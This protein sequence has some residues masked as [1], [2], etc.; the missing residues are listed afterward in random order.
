[1]FNWKSIANDLRLAFRMSTRHPSLKL[2]AVAT[3][4]LGI[5]AN[6]AIFTVVDA[7]IFRQLPY[8]HSEQLVFFQTHMKNG[9]TVDATTYPNFLEWRKQSHSFEEVAAVSPQNLIISGDGEAEPISA[10]LVSADYFGMLRLTPVLGRL[11]TE[12]ETSHAGSAS[13]VIISNGLWKRRFGGDHSV[14]GKTLHLNDESFT[15]VGVLSAGEKGTSQKADVWLPIT[16][17]GVSAT[18]HLL[19]NRVAIWVNVIGRLD[20]GRPVSE[21]QREVEVMAP[22]VAAQYP[23]TRDAGT[24]VHLV[25][26]RYRTV[27]HYREG[28]LI[29]FGA[30]IFVL[31]IACVNVANLLLSYF[32]DRKSEL[33]VR[34]ALGA[35]RFRLV[36]QLLLESI[37][38]ASYGGIV[39]LLLAYLSVQWLGRS[40]VAVFPG[41]H[42]VAINGFVLLFTF[43]ISVVTGMLVGLLPLWQVVR[44]QLIEGLKNTTRSGSG[45]GRATLRAGLIVCQ[46]GLAI[47][48]LVGA[49]LMLR[50]MLNLQKVDVGFK[51]D[52]LLVAR[53]SSLP[54]SRY[55][56]RE[57]M[58]AFY[59][60]I[61][62]QLSRS[63]QVRSVGAVTSFP[64]VTTSP[65]MPFE[66]GG[67]PN[68]GQPPTARYLAVSAGYF[69]TMGIPLLR[70][71]GFD[72]T[73]SFN[74][75]PVIV[76]NQAMANQYWPGSDP[77]GKAITIFD[78][79]T[80]RQVIGVV[81]DIRD[82]SV[83]TVGTAEFYIPYQQ[84]P[85]G[86]VSILRSFPP[87]LAIRTNAP[88]ESL[89]NTLRAIVAGADQNEAVLNLTRVQDLMA[90]SVAQP[91]LY[92]NLLMVFAG[93]A[94]LLAAIGIYGVISYSVMQRSREIGVRLAL[95]AT[96]H[97]ILALVF[98]QGM[99]SILL[100]I[101]G[102]IA[103]AWALS[104]VLHNFLYE[105][106][107]A[108]PVSFALAVGV[109]TAAAGLACYIPAKR[110]TRVDPIA[111]LR[112]D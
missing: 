112:H 92:T 40:L 37:L 64:L 25:P 82:S 19:E 95:G 34:S 77:L 54:A 33:A 66:I 49:G 53:L 68:Q 58:I 44:D 20:S 101:V 36:Q 99:T 17:I 83:N 6:T 28:L 47:I 109:I 102:G 59:D 110:A 98:R 10:E 108:D 104:R 12:E 81:G 42:H 11:F 71:R 96:R 69:S 85:P 89:S 94:L 79:S 105:I 100:G 65:S 22:S 57:K 31:L 84:I 76:L 38:L 27:E 2:I 67:R 5:G 9:Q 15:I 21:A 7:A 103:G 46:M 63:P 91:K 106:K 75:V 56:M 107:P 87:A 3:L 97:N 45:T 52:G 111:I 39:G 1:M 86:F 50:T 23:E 70:G 78:G 61:M 43:I 30:V 90:K 13:L 32:S 73:D 16:M 55:D 41:L 74:T 72:R 48:L 80:P 29:L 8:S 18:S 35:S 60:N 62:E 88:V 14:L 4:A 51:P 26:L 93:I 24:S